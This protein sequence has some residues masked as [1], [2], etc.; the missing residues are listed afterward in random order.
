MSITCNG[1]YL[2]IKTIKT[3]FTIFPPRDYTTKEKQRK[4]VIFSVV[5]LLG[6][7]I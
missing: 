2:N 7:V 6:P 4:D 1:F 3:F 5:R